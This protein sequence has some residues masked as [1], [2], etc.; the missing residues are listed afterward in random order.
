MAAFIFIFY[1]TLFICN[2]IWKILGTRKYHSCFEVINTYLGL[3]LIVIE[4]WVL[5]HF[6]IFSICFVMMKWRQG[7]NSET[8]IS[9]KYFLYGHILKIYLKL[10]Q[11]N[12]PHSNVFDEIHCL[13]RFMIFWSEKMENKLVWT[14]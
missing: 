12:P 14:V 8:S 3:V 7:G 4:F 5:L 11:I 1:F 10:M 2:S 13:F 6:N 9:P